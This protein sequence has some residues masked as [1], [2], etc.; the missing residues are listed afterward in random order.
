M[1]KKKPSA[2]AGTKKL[3]LKT[4]TVKDLSPKSKAGDVKGGRR[5]PV[6]TR[7]GGCY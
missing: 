6:R 7:S 2:R 5:C 4:Q 3:K 1:T